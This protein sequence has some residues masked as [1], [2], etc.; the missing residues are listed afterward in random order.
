[1]R[2]RGRA[3]TREIGG[4]EVDRGGRLLDPGNDLAQMGQITV[5]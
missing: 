3:N 1:M 2:A 5:W 4:W